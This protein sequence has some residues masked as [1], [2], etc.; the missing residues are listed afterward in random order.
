[1]R[2]L[3]AAA[4]VVCVLG[5]AAMALAANVLDVQARTIT[6]ADVAPLH[7]RLQRYGVSSATFAERV[8]RLRREHQERVRDGDFDHLVF[9]MLQSRRFTELAPI[10]PALSAK[11]HHESGRVPDDVSARAAAFVKAL[12]SSSPDARLA[13]F[14]ELVA[15]SFPDRT[16]RPDALLREYARA[17]RFVYEKEF[18]AQRSERSADAVA[19][20]YR[21]RGLS[22]DTA[23]E[24]GY[25][26]Y[27]G[28]GVLKSLEP[29]RRIRRVLIVGPGLDLAPRTG[30]MET[31]PPQ[32][33][34]PW[35]VMDALLGLGLAQRDDLEIVSADINPRVVEHLNRVREDPPV[36]ALA[37]GLL[38]TGIRFSRDYH[39]Y[40]IRLGSAIGSVPHG[41]GKG[42]GQGEPMYKTVR[43]HKEAAR[44][45]RAQRLD[46][47][48][49]RL[50]GAQFD[51]VIATNI[52]PYFDDVE[53][54]LAMSNVA[55]MLALGGVLLHNEPRPSL[56]D[57]TSDLGLS[58]DQLRQAVIATVDGAP[59][60]L[61]DSVYVHRRVPKLPDR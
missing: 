40:F 53:L 5:A 58:F 37:T 41:D 44:L 47:V 49:E 61:A 4:L 35:A 33:Y 26:V 60:P 29:A 11:A 19:E 34:Q 20:L 10:E 48:I 17:M 9:Y 28:L 7:P 59:K 22:T 2:L 43:V 13:F 42:G 39:D 18:V 24:A 56:G 46:I 15:S 16:Q 57:I 36:L 55:A 54:M 30:L 32:S 12:D 50:D 6:W 3:T 38:G 31:A 1:M 14:R 8:A 23:V 52:L 51:V 21:K 25:L 27:Q 45:L